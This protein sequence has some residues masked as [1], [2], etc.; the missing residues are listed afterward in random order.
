MNP[1]KISTHTVINAN[2]LLA[3]KAIPMKTYVH[4][5]VYLDNFYQMI[6]ENCVL[7]LDFYGAQYYFL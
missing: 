1:A 2:N 4:K 5:T 7:K 3:S 6:S